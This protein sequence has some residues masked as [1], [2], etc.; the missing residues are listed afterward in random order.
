MNRCL[1]RLPARHD[2]RTLKLGKYLTALPPTPSARDWTAGK[3][4][5]GQMLNNELG[6]CTCAAL[7]HAC[8]TWSLNSIKLEVTPADADILAAYEKW[9]GYNPAD[10]STDQGGVE[11][12][13]L[14]CFKRDGLAGHFLAAFADP[15]V[16]NLEEVK[17][18][19]NLFGGVYIGITLTNAQ[20][21]ADVWDVIPN[22]QS[23]VAGGHA[24]WVPRYDA[25][26]SFTCIT[27][28]ELKKM[29]A[30]F[31]ASCVDEAH[32][33]LGSLWITPTGAPSGFD[34]TQLQQDL[35]GIS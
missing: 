33:L 10:P 3:T 17:Q 30:A 9:C 1:G 15:A 28:G 13:V 8:Q 19:I 35:A 16:Q 34:L 18:G 7:G 14:N 27:W 20:L 12:T 21:D 4:E 26:G 2:P 25:D 23:G 22:D 32:C 24:V 11:L 5:W 29:T 6:D 31:W